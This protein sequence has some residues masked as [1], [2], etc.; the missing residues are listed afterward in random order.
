LH[1]NV[2]GEQRINFLKDKV[3]EVASIS[4]VVG[5]GEVRFEK[6][7]REDTLKM[8]LIGVTIKSVD[9]RVCFACAKTIRIAP[10]LKVAVSFFHNTG[11]IDREKVE[12]ELSIEDMTLV[13][14]NPEDSTEFIVAG[15]EGAI[16]NK[17]NKGFMLL[18]GEAYLLK[19]E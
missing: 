12:D 2:K 3:T 4:P 11:T 8:K 5:K 19:K 9:G 6:G 1:N 15:K 13:G 7:D 18:E 17:T 16:L 14:S 10:G